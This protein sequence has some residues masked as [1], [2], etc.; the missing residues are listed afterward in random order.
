MKLSEIEFE[1]DAFKEAVL[2]TGLENAEEV[3]EIRARKSSIVKV[4][5]LE[6]F[7]N[8]R[9]LDLTRNRLTDIDL[10][11][12]PLLEEVYLGNNEIEE[13]DLSAN[14]NLTHLEI[15]IN[16]I[17]ELDLTPLTKLENL[18]ANKNDLT[19]LD[20]SNNPFIEQIQVSDNELE[21]LVLP[22][23]VKPFIIKAEN[24]KLDD[25]TISRLKELV[26]D[27]NLKL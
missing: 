10:S 7:P 5:G 8:L 22:E 12:N 1:D 19:E 17:S 15:F 13:I 3:T 6:H 16:D 2:A 24:T 27:H 23:N 11:S 4:N 21:T 26:T 20:L 9:L 14:P 18:Y 25:E